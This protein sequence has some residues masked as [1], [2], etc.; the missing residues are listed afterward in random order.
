MIAAEG[1]AAW[2]SQEALRHA[3]R[4]WLA[5]LFVLGLGYVALVPPFQ[6]IDEIW[7]WERMWSVAQGD[8]N[9]K[10]IPVAAG[11]FVDRTF[12][13]RAGSDP[14]TW[15]LFHDAYHFKGDAGA[16]SIATNACKYPPVGY[17]PA[18][19]ATRLLTGDPA[20]R[21]WHK[22][23]YAFYASRVGNWLWFFGCVL[24]AMRLT[25]YP[26]PVL[27]FA[28]IPMVVQQATAI[29]NDAFQF[30][31]VLLVGAL[32]TRAPTRLTLWSAIVL[33][34]LMS[35]IKPI[36]AIAACLVWIAAYVGMAQERMKR[37]EAGL[38]AVAAAV[39]PL[40]AW[41]L[42]DRT[43]HLAPHGGTTPLP[44][45]NV[46]A[47]AQLA[48]LRA[49]PI[50]FLQVLGWQL[51]Q[52]FTAAPIDGGWRGVL[53]AICGYGMVVPDYVYA[54][55]VAALIAG[56]LVLRSGAA[57]PRIAPRATRLLVVSAVSSFL[58]YFALVT[59]LLYIEFT[60]VGSSVVYGVQGRYYLY[61]IAMMFFLYPMV[62]REP[63]RLSGPVASGL[64]YAFM[65]LSAFGNAAALHAIRWVFWE[66]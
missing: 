28:S 11:K 49:E 23:F 8:Y 6:N 43:M 63:P 18:A 12:R 10:E 65:A 17:L 38:V 64:A 54:L 62:R 4:A 14:L 3:R 5:L 32:L 56:L 51:K 25:R 66:A 50:R 2:A 48:M 52:F 27:L 57:E 29:N 9:C 34:A 39:L 21:A 26:M 37:L 42:W 47:A 46:D 7:H 59:L 15:D 13:F 20:E 45:Q 16:F 60:P 61:F 22:M 44:V 40:A 19:A 24:L 1:M 58:P 55:A 36:N 31:G 33:T 53:L 35:A 30:G 41:V